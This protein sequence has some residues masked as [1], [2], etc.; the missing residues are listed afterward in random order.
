MPFPPPSLCLALIIKFCRF[1]SVGVQSFAPQLLYSYLPKSASRTP[2]NPRQRTN[3]SCVVRMPFA[4]S[5]LWVLRVIITAKQALVGEH[6]IVLQRPISAKSLQ[7][8]ETRTLINTSSKASPAPGLIL[9]VGATV[10]DSIAVFESALF[11][12]CTEILQK[13]IVVRCH[14]D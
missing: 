11:P 10:P 4:P 14:F 3:F 13:E 7:I 1:S 12:P 5:V 9:F 8:R 6:V 2:R